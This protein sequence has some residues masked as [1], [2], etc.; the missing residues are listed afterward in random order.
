MTKS[1]FTIS[2][3]FELFW[4]VRDQKSIRNYGNNILGVREAIPAILKLF[5]SHKIHA[6]WATVGFVTFA[7]RRELMAY[8]P[9][10]APGY[11]DKNLDPYP[12]L[13]RIG[14]NE[15]DDPYHY[16]YSLVSKILDTPG[17]ELASHSFSHF[18]CLE[19]RINS[20]AHFADLEASVATLNRLGVKANS[21]IFARNQYD[22]DHLIEAAACGFRVFRG[23]ESRSIYK[24]RPAADASI[25]P[26]LARL[27]DSYFNLA[28]P[29]LAS[30]SRD[31]S[32]L[33]NVP[34]SRFLRPASKNLL[35]ELRLA[36]I[37]DAMTAAAISGSC[38]HLWWH[39]HNFGVNLIQNLSF[40]NKILL[41]FRHLQNLYG[42]QSMT[43]AEVAETTCTSNQV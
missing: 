30:I 31:D 21:L 35:E 37:L 22:G 39:P 34:S 17:M 5:L 20:G 4:G 6:T 33:V 26:R 15:Q 29:N 2:L 41:H 40:L 38:F 19:P 8:M 16:G 13:S 7:T 12:H 1:I 42:M 18:Y 28:G 10:I 11:L 23:T 24:S 43:M 36:R 9:N 27:V 3:D 32:G 14:S 25:F